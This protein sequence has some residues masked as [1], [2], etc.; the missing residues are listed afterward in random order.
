M[1]YQKKQSGHS[2]ACLGY[3]WMMGGN[4]LKI[5]HQYEG[6]GRINSIYSFMT[7]K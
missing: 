2:I 1:K 3:T 6:E 5:N 7:K 4:Q